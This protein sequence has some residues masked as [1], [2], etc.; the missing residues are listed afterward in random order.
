MDRKQ[1]T[2]KCMCGCGK[3]VITPDKVGREVKF[4]K[5]HCINN[6]G[7]F[8]RDSGLGNQYAKTH[9]LSYTKIYSIWK[10]M[11]RRCSP[12]SK[13]HRKNYFERNIT[14]CKEWN[15]FE[16]FYNWVI[17]SEYK[18]GFTIDRIDV[19]KG[20]SPNNC[21]WATPK[22]QSNNRQITKSFTYNEKTLSLS[23]WADVTELPYHVVFKR[24]KKGWTP[25]RII[26][27]PLVKNKSH[28][29]DDRSV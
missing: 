28:K 11:K 7:R 4:A 24:F 16:N 19:N 12:K 23:E 13:D 17:K 25:K 3:E 15:I 18:T 2:R 14:V 20:Y 10:G 1:V 9:G 6:S 5:G 29:K 27:T 22:Q 8:T 26:E 21:R